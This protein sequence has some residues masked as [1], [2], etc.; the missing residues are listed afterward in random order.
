MNMRE[1]IIALFVAMSSVGYA[2]DPKRLEGGLQIS[3]H[4]QANYGLPIQVLPTANGLVP[5]LSLQY[6]GH[7]QQTEVGQGWSISAGSYIQRCSQ[8]D[9]ASRKIAKPLRLESDDSY[10][11]G[12]NRLVAVKGPNGEDGSE[13]RS[14]VDDGIKV[15]AIG[16]AGK[17]PLSFKV[18]R[19]SGQI[20]TYGWREEARLAD[21]QSGT[22][23]TWYLSMVDDRHANRID[24]LYSKSPEN[25]ILLQEINYGGNTKTGLQP[26]RAVSFEYEKNPMALRQFNQGIVSSRASSLN[27]I[28]VWSE[29]RHVWS[30][31]F[32]YKPQDEVNGRILKSVRMCAAD[33][34]CT[35]STEFD[36][37]QADSGTLSSEVLTQEFVPS[38]SWLD[39]VS[40][41]ILI[42]VNH[43]G[44]SDILGVVNL[45]NK[46]NIVVS[47]GSNDGF[48]PAVKVEISSISDWKSMDG[49]PVEAADFNRDGY[50]DV[51]IGGTSG[52]YVVYGT[53][54]GFQHSLVK[55]Y[56]F[57]GVGSES[58]RSIYSVGEANGDGYPDLIA[59]K[60]TGTYLALG[61]EEGFAEPRLL[62]DDIGG[63]PKWKQVVF[64]RYAFDINSDGYID[65]IGFNDNGII[66]SLGNPDADYQPP[67]LWAPRMLVDWRASD[68]Q[69]TFA[70]VNGD[71]NID[72]VGRRWQGIWVSLGTGKSFL[73]PELWHS[74]INTQ[75]CPI[76]LGQLVANDLNQDGFADF[77]LVC[78]KFTDILFG[79]GVPVKDAPKLRQIFS[80]SDAWLPKLPFFVDDTN[81][82]GRPDINIFLAQGLTSVRGNWGKTKLIRVI[83]GFKFEQKLS[84]SNLTEESLYSIT[85]TK[86]FPYNTLSG[87]IPVVK[88]VDTSN[89][90]GGFNR[91]S[92][93][94][95]NALSHFQLGFLG[96]ETFTE[97]DEARSL[98]VVTLNATNVENYLYGVPLE[99]STYLLSEGRQILKSQVFGW[100]VRDAFP[101]VVQVFN[102]TLTER[103]YAP[104]S[105][106]LSTTV[107]KKAFD[108]HLNIERAESSITDAYDTYTSILINEFEHDEASWLLSRLKTA[109]TT[110]YRLSNP[111]KL[112]KVATFEYDGYGNVEFELSEPGTEFEKKT[113]YK[114]NAL[115]IVTNTKIW[116]KNNEGIGLPWV[117]AS[118]ETDDRGFA[119]FSKNALGQVQQYSYHPDYGSKITET[120]PNGL[121]TSYEYDRWGRLSLVTRPDKVK[122]S[123]DLMWCNFT[124]PANAVIA[125]TA[126]QDG[127]PPAHTYYDVFGRSLRQTQTSPD[128]RIVHADNEFDNLGLQKRSTRPYF[129]GD[130]PQSTYYFYDALLRL[131]TVKYPDDTSERYEYEGFNKTL[132]D[133]NGHKTTIISNALGQKLKTINAK[134]EELSFSYTL[135]GH[136]EHVIAP[137]GVVVS[138]EYDIHGRVKALNDPSIGKI[139]RKYNSL[140]LVYEV[141]RN[142][143]AVTR[144]QYDALGRPV[145]R[146]DEVG[147]PREKKSTWIY[148]A[149]PNAVGKLS[150]IKG[151]RH[152]TS[153]SYDGLGRS[154]KVNVT[155]DR[156]VYSYVYGYDDLSRPV[157]ILYPSG[158]KEQNDYSEA[159]FISR[160]YS[161]DKTYW[162]PTEYYADGAIAAE[163]L[164]N[165]VL[166]RYIQD[167][168]N[169]RILSI[170]SESKGRPIHS[171]HVGHDAAGNIESRRDLMTGHVESFDYDSL[172]RLKEARSSI[173]GATIFDYDELGNLKSVNGRDRVS[174]YK[175]GTDCGLKL[176]N[177]LAVCQLIETDKIGALVKETAYSYDMNGAV[178]KAGNKSMTYDAMGLPIV[179]QKGSEQ[180]NFSYSPQGQRFEREDV[181]PSSKGRTLYLPHGL[182]LIEADDKT[183]YRHTI[184]DK[185]VIRMEGSR[186]E[187]K[188]LHG[189]H[190]GSIL[191][192]SDQ[193]GEVT[194]RFVFEPWGQRLKADG[195]QFV[196][197]LSDTTLRGYTGHEMLDNIGLVHM[198]GR[199]YDS[200]LRRFIS[201]DPYIQD[202][203]NLQS[204]NRYAYCWNNPMT[205]TDPSGYFSI[206][207]IGREI[208]R[209]GKSISRAFSRLDNWVRDNRS[210]VASIAFTAVAMAFC[211][212]AGFAAYAYAGAVGFT[213]SYIA[214]NGDLNA[215]ARGAIVGMAFM[216]VGDIFALSSVKESLGGL[217]KA[218]K[219]MAHGT[220]G[221]LS[222]V[223]GKG[224]FVSGFMS[225]GVSQAA[226]LG[227]L[228][229]A[230]GA[231]DKPQG[232]GGFLWNAVASGVVGG[233][234]SS[235][236]GGS[237]EHGALTAA[238]GR[239]MNDLVH[240]DVSGVRARIASIARS[241]GDGRK[242]GILWNVWDAKGPY[243]PNTNKCNLFVHDVLVEAGVG[244][245]MANGGVLY[246]YF[247]IGEPKYPI[248]AG[249]WA[250]PSYDIK[251]WRVVT[252][253]VIPGDIIAEAHN[254]SDATGHVGIVTGNNL[255][256]SAS[257]LRQGVIVENSWGFRAQNN[258]TI[259]RYFGE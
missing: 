252:G 105:N 154:E 132:F 230:I 49:Y 192:I 193:N 128:G 255:S 86:N 7:A 176:K 249:Q 137:K 189:D 223:A 226:S 73:L 38:R 165:G 191:A 145:A 199:V 78:G 35:A 188:Y 208:S 136:Q 109:S 228:Y 72:I 27:R 146:I 182:E 174:T 12:S 180:V 94:Y 187:E 88:H 101:G 233:T 222:S 213:S 6:S 26:Y 5:T 67:T 53:A 39:A 51:L 151:Q 245:A 205:N 231:A 87:A 57:L 221:G 106:V 37:E 140:D 120:D 112:K 83:D 4:G 219:V 20:E 179:L 212:P 25:E 172:N 220:V 203:Y 209:A 115:G 196:Q 19:K 206:G 135:A 207:D 32:T 247:G 89:G 69:T 129:E 242:E 14:A 166:G 64:K 210:S 254:Y 175:Y 144:F 250:D 11:L 30:Y 181:G 56:P 22:V 77:I 61:S 18:Y 91:T 76:N 66:V 95:E 170:L 45:F 197:N 194:E 235:A 103:N 97:V 147:T 59:F 161:G 227:G 257:S 60:G 239:L 40:R 195:S 117:S 116:L 123:T 253:P 149:G 8:L 126:K 224:S 141:V 158:F 114:R 71:G 143:G 70:D 162:T 85:R 98:E 29:G 74:T 9:I 13:Y 90:V 2:Q 155:I 58:D 10:C 15:I 17:G 79:K 248:L 133:P 50:A 234:A 157:S 47:L 184:A 118:I 214:S 204:I 178:L 54:N 246:N 104:G 93:R 75:E 138:Y 113:E 134:S 167:E 244:Q 200:E 52:F 99:T 163:Q 44:I 150:E 218:S 216:G 81:S 256:T 24:Y 215:A 159:G 131:E 160:I 177:P 31:S 33:G 23:F 92:Y 153:Y 16:Q 198:N 127:L 259:R 139:R 119:K 190:Q 148:D 110:S 152:E 229:Q 82:D 217:Y 96:F 186:Y 42:D 41:R 238:M 130:Q 125:L 201:P 185:V 232:I 36:Y 164:G 156:K 236:A 107:T 63:L 240:D 168:R 142:D 111:M 171:L 84:W 46:P 48:S 43:D 122:S 1:T 173:S 258:V 108:A 28:H 65:I 183:I 80:W 241:Y 121:T 211:P 68:T 243:G 55:S 169:G 100:K 237:F 21:T 34:I 251:G 225:A 3:E 124:C 102:E 202:P 62:F